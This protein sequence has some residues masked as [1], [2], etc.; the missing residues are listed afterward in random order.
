MSS[1]QLFLLTVPAIAP[2]VILADVML[3][4]SSFPV[5]VSVY[6]SSLLLFAAFLKT[7]TDGGVCVFPQVATITKC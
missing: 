2:P 7:G 1:L 5:L 6:P 4:L 3:P